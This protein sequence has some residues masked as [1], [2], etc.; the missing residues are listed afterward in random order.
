MKNLAA[1][2]AITFTVM[3]GAALF[4]FSEG[5]TLFALVLLGITTVAAL[6]IPKASNKKTTTN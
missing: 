1:A 4:S 3:I 2:V 6:S 5:S